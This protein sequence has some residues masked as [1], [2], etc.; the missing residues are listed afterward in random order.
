M[1]S[2]LAS[3]L[4][5]AEGSTPHQAIVLDTQAPLAMQMP[6]AGLAAESGAPILTS[7]GATLP[8]ATTAALRLL[9]HPSIYVMDAAEMSAAA[10][11]ALARLG[12]VT[13]IAGQ[14][15]SEEQGATAN[16]IAVARF[17]DGTFG[18]G[19]KEPGHG[20]V[21]ANAGRPFDAPAAALLSATGEYGPLLLLQSAATIPASLSSYL[22]DIQPAYSSAPEFSAVK[23][24]YNHG[25]LIGDERAISL[26]MQARLDS[27]LEIS[28]RRSGGTTA[29]EAPA[30]SP[31]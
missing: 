4:A 2:A 25:W 9:H 6:A 7:A 1:A 21:F 27:M 18:W 31:E 26:V 12:S 24:V 16:S 3:V 23:G 29:E 17:S 22:A 30:V 11:G 19:V 13:R 5:R 14:S 8:G 15:T 28:Y 20:L 10:L